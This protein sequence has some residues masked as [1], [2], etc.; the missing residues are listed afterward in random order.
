MVNVSIKLDI[1]SITLYKMSSLID[2]KVYKN[3]ILK[4]LVN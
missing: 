3:T 4:L 2:K 1:L